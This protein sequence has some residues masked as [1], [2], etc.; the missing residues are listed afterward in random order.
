L[1]AG[2]GDF[3]CDGGEPV[4]EPVAWP[5]EMTSQWRKPVQDGGG[6]NLVAEYLARS[7]K[8]LLLVSK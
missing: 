5:I 3:G 1:S 2:A 6:Q 7:E 4:L 8:A